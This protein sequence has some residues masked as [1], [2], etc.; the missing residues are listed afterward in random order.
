MPEKLPR[1]DAFWDAHLGLGLRWRRSSFYTGWDFSFAF[2]GFCV[3]VSTGA[4]VERS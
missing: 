3:I 1:F 2:P 4:R